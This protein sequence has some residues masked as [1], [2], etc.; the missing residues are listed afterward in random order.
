MN[1][2]LSESLL[3]NLLKILDT[4]NDNEISMDEFEAVFAKHLGGGGPVEVKSAKE[5]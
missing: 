5:Y 1:I 3:T 2:A 4:D